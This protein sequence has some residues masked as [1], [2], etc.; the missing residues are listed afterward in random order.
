MLLLL[1][2][3]STLAAPQ[4]HPLH[5]PSLV[6][7]TDGR[8]FAVN[9]HLQPGQLFQA[10]DGRVFTLASSSGLQAVR[11]VQVQAGQ[12]AVTRQ[13]QQNNFVSVGRQEE[14]G[15]E[16]HVYQ[17]R[18]D[19]KSLED[20]V[21]ETA[22][23]V[24]A[25]FVP[26]PSLVASAQASAGSFQVVAKSATP[27]VARPATPLVARPAVPVVVTKPATPFRF[28]ERL[29]PTSP[30]ARAGPVVEQ[31]QQSQEP[32]RTQQALAPQQVRT[33][34]QAAQPL[35]QPLGRSQQQPLLQ[36]LG[37]G[38]QQPLL[39]FTYFQQPATSFGRAQSLPLASDHHLTHPLAATNLLQSSHL[40]GQSLHPLQTVSHLQPANSPNLLSQPNG[41]FYTSFFSFPSAG[42]DFNF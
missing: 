19:L 22:S 24:A 7:H 23:V 17:T 13:R 4:L 34:I 16:S 11:P 37:L 9:A 3:P 6:Q 41:D 28:P 38:Q 20:P 1:L 27:P 10:G 29:L 8:Y 31:Q 21:Q 14:E 40:Q 42:V 33:Q 25:K 18:P 15:P 36:P 35:L 5:P 39:P 32:A 2:L 26:Q 30:T 12:L